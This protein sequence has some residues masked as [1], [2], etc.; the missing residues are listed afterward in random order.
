[1][2]N[3][4]ANRR[5]PRR[6]S[7][8]VKKR[9]AV[10][11]ILTM[12]VVAAMAFIGIEL[13]IAK[14]SEDLY[15]EVKGHSVTDIDEEANLGAASYT[16]LDVEGEAIL[17]KTGDIEILIDTGAESS[18][19]KLIETLKGK[20]DGNID[21]LVLTA[22]SDKRLGGL[23][24]LAAEFGINTCILGE[25][26][27]R[28]K[29]ARTLLESCGEIIDGKD[30][31]IDLREGVS[32]SILKP[33][34][35]SKQ[36]GD[37]SL[38]TLFAFGEATFMS[39]SDAG[40]EEISRVSANL[41]NSN[42]IVLAR[43]GS[44]SVNLK[45]PERKYGISYIVTGDKVSGAPTD[46]LTEYLDSECY[47]VWDEGEIEFTTDGGSVNYRNKADEEEI[48]DEDFNGGE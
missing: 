16:A 20:V 24:R 28:D 2:A 48:K 22:P 46:K 14:H 6:R 12:L 19:D 30:L 3:K 32:F 42:V 25:M 36:V 21:Y 37:K 8:K 45:L 27:E 4:N 41:E 43:F 10:I 18:A 44:E 5:R 39:L 26:G 40:E 17:I 1:M 15:G 31:T 34:V 47:S 9:F 38:V 23:S 13:Y 29:E 11:S 7:R 33:E 35:S